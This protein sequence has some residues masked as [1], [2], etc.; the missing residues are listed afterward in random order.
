MVSVV[1][2]D[3]FC[4]GGLAVLCFCVFVFGWC[5]FCFG[6]LVVVFVGRLVLG[7]W[8]SPVFV[9]R[10]GGGGGV[11]FFW[12]GRCFFFWF[13]LCFL[14]FL[15]CRVFGSWRFWGWLVAG[16]LLVLGLL[17]GFVCGFVGGVPFL[18][19]SG[20]VVCVLF[21]LFFLGWLGVFLGFVVWVAFK[22]FLV[23]VCV[24]VW[25]CCCFLVVC[26]VCCCVSCV[27]GV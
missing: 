7:W 11:L 2:F 24:F 1:V 21:R 27:G 10:W 26:F 3:F 20:G 25:V 16:G 6:W 17:L 23:C 5:C 18:F 15:C 4:G 8:G 9:V 12:R 22:V 14:C 13:F 19:V